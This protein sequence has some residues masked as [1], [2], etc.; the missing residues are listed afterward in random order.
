MKS[1]KD[2]ERTRFVFLGFPRGA[3]DVLGISQH[4]LQR[5]APKEPLWN[6]TGN[7]MEPQWIPYGTPYGTPLEPQ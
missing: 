3:L 7:S 4:I 6:P 5:T 2:A 1:V